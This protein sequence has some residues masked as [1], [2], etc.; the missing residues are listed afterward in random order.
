VGSESGRGAL[1]GSSLSSAIPERLI[2]PTPTPPSKAKA[3]PPTPA[4]TASPLLRSPLVPIF[5]RTDRPLAFTVPA[6]CRMSLLGRHDDDLGQTWTVQCGSA[7]ANRA[8][9]E[10]AEQQDWKLLQGNPPIGVGMQHYTK[11]GIWMSIAHRLDG[12]GLAADF[13]L[14]QTLRPA[15]GNGADIPRFY[16]GPSCGFVDPPSRSGTAAKWALRCA[17]VAGAIQEIEAY[18]LKTGWRLISVATDPYAT[19]RYCNGS[20]EALWRSGADFDPG[21]VLLTETEGACP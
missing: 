9:V 3:S 2:T 13:S 14:V 20:L 4:P 21:I 6:D 18:N 17:D 16:N 10:A 5:P 7:A 12:P 15:V 8:V 19:R 11:D 1:S